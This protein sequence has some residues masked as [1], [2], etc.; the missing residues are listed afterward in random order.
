MANKTTLRD[1][2]ATYD[3]AKSENGATIESNWRLVKD[4]PISTRHD[5]CGRT[6]DTRT[7]YLESDRQ[8]AHFAPMADGGRRYEMPDGKAFVCIYKLTPVSTDADGKPTGF[9][10]YLF[11]DMYDGHGNVSRA[12][13]LDITAIKNRVFGRQGWTSQ[14][15][16][17]AVLNAPTSRKEVET[18]TEEWRKELLGHLEEVERILETYR[19]STLKV[20]LTL[21]KRVV[22]FKVRRHAEALY[23]EY[24]AQE[25]ERKAEREAKTLK[26]T[27]VE[28]IT[29]ADA[30]LKVLAAQGFTLADLIA[31]SK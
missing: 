2:F 25:A 3:F 24:A 11:G 28:D 5:G 6:D 18:Y 19:G 31:A 4:E 8:F 15:G 14:K 13:W 17:R 26:K 30:M 12:E 22:K 10:T 1:L 7:V 16:P 29:S 23:A 20:D 21:A 9:K 27:K